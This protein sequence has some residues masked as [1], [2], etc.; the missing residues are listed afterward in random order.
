MKGVEVGLGLGLGLVGVV[1]VGVGYAKGKGKREGEE[2]KKGETTTELFPMETVMLK[3]KETTVTTV[4]FFA[5][6]VR[7]AEDFLKPRM[8]A[9]LQKNR[10]LAGAVGIKRGKGV[11]T[12]PGEEA[13]HLELPPDM[14]R[15]YD[16]DGEVSLHRGTDYAA[17]ANCLSHRIVKAGPTNLVWTV[18]LI[19]DAREPSTRFALVTSMAH[20]VGDGCTYYEIHNQLTGAC[21]IRA[22]SPLRDWGVYERMREACT[23]L[24]E[25]F[26]GAFFTGIAFRMLYGLVTRKKPTMR[27]VYVNEEWVKAQKA[28]V[29]SATGGREFISTN[30]AV[31]SW[32]FA[33]MGAPMNLMAINFRG[34][35]ENCSNDNAGNYEDMVYYLSGDADEPLQIRRSLKGMRRT[36]DSQ[37]GSTLSRLLG[38]GSLC[39]NWSTFAK[40]ARIDK[41][42][43][44]LHLPLFKSGDLP[45]GWALCVLFK[46][47]AA[48]TGI[49]LLSYQDPKDVEP[50]GDA[51]GF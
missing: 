29:T 32:F 6:D 39:T 15:V 51:I 16:C 11:L 27:L 20:A 46:P 4:T 49:L 36:S 3:E 45:Y 2:G 9:I 40:P 7:D 34:R 35:I 5:G 28:R 8:E 13:G 22:I 50:M 18:T 26:T 30:D 38:K 1:V 48:R 41:V 23:T 37:L 21:A 14:F 12:F 24:A 19:P 42:V 10:W 44:D 25:V 31:T 47:D 17:F 33:D 43:P